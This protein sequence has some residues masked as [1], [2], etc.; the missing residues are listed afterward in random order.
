[1]IRYCCDIARI[2]LTPF[3]LLDKINSITYYKLYNN[4]LA[5]TLV[6]QCYLFITSPAHHLLLLILLLE[7]QMQSNLMQQ[8]KDTPVKTLNAYRAQ[9]FEELQAEQIL[10]FNI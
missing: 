2:S 9:K 3:L 7:I 4:E 10:S 6:F 8:E 5:G 1:M